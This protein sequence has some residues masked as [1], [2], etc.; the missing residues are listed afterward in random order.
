MPVCVC[1]C[2]IGVRLE[3]PHLSL[4]L[5]Y[6]SVLLASE[7]C[8]TAASCATATHVRA[9]VGIG[10]TSFIGTFAYDAT[11]LRGIAEDM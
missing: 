11:G 5:F 4:L 9:K 7:D 10:A 3:H 1:C 8:T 6:T 2:P